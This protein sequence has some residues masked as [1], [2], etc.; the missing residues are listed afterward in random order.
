MGRKTSLSAFFV[1]TSTTN[2]NALRGRDRIHANWCVSSFL[3][4]FLLVWKGDEVKV[5][6][7]D[8]QPFIATLDYVEAS[9]YGQGFGPII[10]K[11]KKKNGAQ[12]EIYME[13]RDTSEIQYQA[14]KLIN[15]TTILPFRQIKGLINE[16]IDD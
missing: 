10:F 11:G 15:T 4:Q 6:W 7:A 9:Y 12:N 13:S 2:Y 1:I 3:Y 16:E 8:K 14:T 5:A